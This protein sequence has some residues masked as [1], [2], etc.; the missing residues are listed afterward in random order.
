MDAVAKGELR[1]GIVALDIKVLA[2]GILGLIAVGRTSE[3]Q[4]LGAFRQLHPAD[5]LGVAYLAPPADDRRHVS[6]H[7]L[8]GIRYFSWIILDRFPRIGVF[9]QRQD[10]VAH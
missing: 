6:Q 10:I 3:H 4:Y 5:S 7:F 1:P 2:V 8:Y 9:H